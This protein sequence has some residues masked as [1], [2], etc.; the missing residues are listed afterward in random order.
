[1]SIEKHKI[2]LFQVF[3]FLFFTKMFILQQCLN[4]NPYPNPNFFRIRIQPK[5]S[6]YFGF[7]STTLEIISII[8]PFPFPAVGKVTD[9]LA[10][11]ALLHLVVIEDF[12]LNTGTGYRYG[13]SMHSFIGIVHKNLVQDSYSWLIV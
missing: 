2:F 8:I 5:Y 3:D 4:P 11:R 10:V 1:L 12:S 13:T 9:L 6:D 7:G